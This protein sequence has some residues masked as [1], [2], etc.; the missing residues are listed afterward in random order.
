ML[1]LDTSGTATQR[2]H[3]EHSHRMHN[4]EV[5]NQELFVT[6]R[7]QNKWILAES[8]DAK[9]PNDIEFLEYHYNRLIRKYDVPFEN[10]KHV[11]DICLRYLDRE[12]AEEERQRLAHQ[13]KVYED[14]VQRHS[15]SIRLDEEWLAEGGEE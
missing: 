4:L 15:K 11:K 14:E 8:G 5:D 7:E 10:L 1:N 6:Q 9:E 12:K 13:L 2:E 3:M